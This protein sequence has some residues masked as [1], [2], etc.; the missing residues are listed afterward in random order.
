MCVQ[1][2]KLKINSERGKKR[3]QVAILYKAKYSQVKKNSIKHIPKTSNK[4]Y[5][6]L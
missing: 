6:R 2:L 4:K 1:K 5:Q 3:K